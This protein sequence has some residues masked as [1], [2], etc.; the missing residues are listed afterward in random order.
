[1]IIDENT[2]YVRDKII[3]YFSGNRVKSCYFYKEKI[4]LSSLDLQIK[5]C[6]YLV[7]LF[8]SLTKKLRSYWH[9][10]GAH[11]YKNINLSTAEIQNYFTCL[12]RSIYFRKSSSFPGT[13]TVNSQ[14]LVAHIFIIS[15]SNDLSVG[16][17]KS[18]CYLLN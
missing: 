15:F 2:F 13:V 11:I 1:M 10:G 9:C 7:Q 3:L 16:S 8:R 14:F 5:Y 12:C 4:W 18:L 6:Y 17:G